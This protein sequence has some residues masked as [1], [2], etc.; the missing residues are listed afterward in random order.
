MQL[1]SEVLCLVNGRLFD[2][3]SY[4][5]T[6]VWRSFTRLES[7]YYLVVHASGGDEWRRDAALECLGPFATVGHA[8]L[9]MRDLLLGSATDR[10]LERAPRVAMALRDLEDT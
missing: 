10:R 8:M 9:A 5:V 1:Q 6:S 2:A 4:E 3:E 7:G